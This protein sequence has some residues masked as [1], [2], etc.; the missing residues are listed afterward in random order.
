MLDT[1]IL[2]PITD[3]LFTAV[4]SVFFVFILVNI[5]YSKREEV[6]LATI[7]KLSALTDLS[8]SGFTLLSDIHISV[9]DLYQQGN[10]RAHELKLAYKDKLET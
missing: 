7:A 10:S 3:L 6:K 1:K 5:A 2:K 9:K 8:H 4:L